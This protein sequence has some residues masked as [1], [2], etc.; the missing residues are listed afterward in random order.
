MHTPSAL[1]TSTGDLLA[2]RV[3]DPGWASGPLEVS[4]IGKPN[5]LFGGIQVETFLDRN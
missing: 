1:S 4:V 2:R 3:V 5:D